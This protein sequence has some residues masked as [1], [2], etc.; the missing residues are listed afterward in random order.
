MI[1]NT[2][3]QIVG[4]FLVGQTGSYASHL[5]IGCGT[6]PI[7]TSGSFADYSTTTYMGFEMLRVPI[8]SRTIVNEDNVSKIIFTAELPTTERYAITEI[9][10]YP[11]DSNPLSTGSDS[12]NLL[13][14]TSG[15]NWKSHET[16]VLD[17]VIRNGTITDNLNNINIADEA[18]FT[19]SENAL[20]ESLINTERI[21]R[22]EQPRFLSSTLMIR[23]DSSTLTTDGSDL[24]ATGLHVHTDISVSDLAINSSADKIKLAFSV[25]NKDGVGSTDIPSNVKV[26]VQFASTDDSSAEYASFVVNLSNG[27]STGQWDFENNRYVVVE[28]SLGDLFK[29]NGFSWESVA[30][31]KVFACV[32][33]GSTGAGDFYVALDA[34]RIENIS[35][36]SS[37]YGLTAYTEVKTSDALPI[38]KVDNSLGLIEFK[39]VVDV[40]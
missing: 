6:K 4:R 36:F 9:G 1:T 12:R 29:T 23:G 19:T 28:K 26:L 35:S 22:Y 37:V 20:F 27:T 17:T 10:V 5:A 39:Y 14:F 3:K 38:V 24:D 2:G 31:A 7:L 16:E 13:L 8:I 34:M 15:E 25:V 11:N 33:N 18:F 21:E 40:L 32:N 30:Y